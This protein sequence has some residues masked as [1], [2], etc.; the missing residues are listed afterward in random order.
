[1]TSPY[2]SETNQLI[3]QLPLVDPYVRLEASAD[4]TV[5]RKLALRNDPDGSLASDL[6]TCTQALMLEGRS[7]GS[8]ISLVQ[9][10]VHSPADLLLLLEPLR[11]SGHTYVELSVDLTPF[12][13]RGQGVTEVLEEI[14]DPLTRV[15]TGSAGL[16]LGL[17][18][19]IP[20]VLTDEFLVELV[21]SYQT[22]PDLLRGVTLLGSGQWSPHL[23]RVFQKVRE[24]GLS[25]S[26]EVGPTNDPQAVWDLIFELK[27]GRLE[28][29]LLTAPAPNLVKHLRVTQTPVSLTPVVDLATNDWSSGP[30]SHPLLSFIDEGLLA[31]PSTGGVG[32]FGDGLTQNYLF[33]LRNGEL[34]RLDLE[35][36]VQNAV[37]CSFLPQIDKLRFAEHIRAFFNAL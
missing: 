9:S 37:K 6:S 3:P 22:W 34:G 32:V 31:Y 26:A 33:L 36:V 18:R 2:P 8:I 16:V 12:L 19:T 30:D 24:M 15:P 21:D 4:P 28:R 5:L 27:V 23:R 35:M 10:L 14:T 11:S 25:T 17:D 29:L 13:K 7:I 20:S 1:M